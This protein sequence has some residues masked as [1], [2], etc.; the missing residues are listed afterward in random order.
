MRPPPTRTSNDFCSSA[1]SSRT[2]LAFVNNVLASISIL[3][4]DRSKTQVS[5]SGISALARRPA[6]QSHYLSNPYLTFAG[7]NIRWNPVVLCFRISALE[8]PNVDSQSSSEVLGWKSNAVEPVGRERAAG[9]LRSESG[10]QGVPAT[11]R[12]AKSYTICAVGDNI[13]QL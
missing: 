8:A 13:R 6:V 2:R 1:N 3:I 9:Q 12:Q 7:V 4:T 5:F 10:F 11:P